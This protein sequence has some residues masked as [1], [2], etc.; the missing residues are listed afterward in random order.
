[1]QQTIFSFQIWDR[2]QMQF[3][4]PVKKFQ[5]F[6]EK[7]FTNVITDISRDATFMH[8]YVVGNQK[9]N[10]KKIFEIEWTPF[11]SISLNPKNIC[12]ECKTNL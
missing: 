1:M 3:G 7:Y 8:L 2:L 9:N 12:L 4:V 11:D 6:K 10:E 5:N